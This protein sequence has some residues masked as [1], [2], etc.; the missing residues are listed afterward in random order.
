M[1]RVN[2]IAIRKE[3]ERWTSNDDNEKA[4]QQEQEEEREDVT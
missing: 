1:R 2:T 4:E 3:T